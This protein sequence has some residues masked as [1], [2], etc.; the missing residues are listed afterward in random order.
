MENK[1]TTT[2]T[3]ATTTTATAYTIAARASLDNG[4]AITSKALAAAGM[5]TRE[6]RAAFA[7]YKESAATL[8]AALCDVSA[9]I[10]TDGNANAETAKRLVSAASRFMGYFVADKAARVAALFGGRKE[11]NAQV[12]ARIAAALAPIAK[13]GTA[14]TVDGVRRGSINANADGVT[15]APARAAL[16]QWAVDALDNVAAMNAAALIA[17]KAAKRD[18]RRAA[19]AA[20]AAAVEQAAK[21]AAAKVDAP[22]AEKAAA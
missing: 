19:K 22:A 12:A 8:I 14:K 5:E 10:S 21:D 17:D 18:A 15:S 2:T 7:A 20:Q 4:K 9:E 11:T 1:N 6:A 13:N 3:T 16:E